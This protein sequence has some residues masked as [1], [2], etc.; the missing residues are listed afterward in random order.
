MW[1]LTLIFWVEYN[2]GTDIDVPLDGN[3]VVGHDSV[4]RSPDSKIA[5]EVIGQ[6]LS[7]EHCRK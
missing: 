5:V 1:T 3:E 4:R 2:G 7:F 6:E